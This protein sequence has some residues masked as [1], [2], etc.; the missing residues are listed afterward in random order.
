MNEQRL[1]DWLLQGDVSIQYQTHRDLLNVD[2]K[3]L[4]KRIAT[5]GWG[6]KYLSKRKKEGHWGKGF[7]SPK[8]ISSHYTLLDLRNLCISPENPLIKNSIENILANEKG[9]DGGVLPIG[10]TQDSDVCVNGMF[11]NY[12]VILKQMRGS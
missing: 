11:L 5:E 7:Y 6:K 4:Q 3:D 1:I 10:A 8:W 2:R 9:P 12:R